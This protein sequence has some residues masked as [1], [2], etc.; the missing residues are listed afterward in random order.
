MALSKGSLYLTN[1]NSMPVKTARGSELLGDSL[2]LRTISA[3]SL[4][5]LSSLDVAGI[6]AGSSAFVAESNR[7]GS[8]FW[9]TSD[10]SEMVQADPTGSMFVPPLSDTSGESGVW[11]RKSNGRY[12]ALPSYFGARLDGVTDDTTALQ[13]YADFLA[14][15][16]DSSPA[17]SLDD[18]I[19]Q[20]AF[21]I[22][23]CDGSVISDKLIIPKNVSVI[24]DGPLLVAADASEAK[25]WVEI[26]HGDSVSSRGCEYTI[27]VRRLT[28]SDWASEE[29]V[30]CSIDTS[31]S[32]KTWLKRID[33]FCIGAKVVTAYSDITLG[34]FRDCKKGM[35]VNHTQGQFTNQCTF[36]GGEFAV[37]NGSNNGKSR[38]GVEIFDD[39]L[40]NGLNSIR[41]SGPSFELNYA[42]A[43]DG[44]PSA[45]SIP[46]IL[47][48]VRMSQFDSIRQ[49]GT[50]P[51]TARLLNDS[52][53]NIF[54]NIYSDEFEHPENLSIDDQSTYKM[55][56]V[57][58]HAT[59]GYSFYNKHLAFD[60]GRLSDRLSYW[61]SS[62]FMLKDMETPWQV[63]EGG[64][65]NSVY[66]DLPVVIE[67]NS[68]NLNG[69][70]TLGSTS[71]SIVGTRFKTTQ[72]KDF[73]V[74]VEFPSS[75]DTVSMF[76]IAFDENGNQVYDEG[77]VLIDANTP[78]EPANPNIY[79]GVF[80]YSSR[81]GA[82]RRYTRF[83]VRDDIKDIFI[84]LSNGTLIG[85]RVYSLWSPSSV[86][87]EGMLR[88]FGRKL[89]QR[90]P[91]LGDYSTGEIIWYE[92]A[93]PGEPAG[94]YVTQGGQYRSFTTAVTA[95]TVSGSSFV[96]LSS[97]SELSRGFY[98]DISGEGTFRIL[99]IQGSVARLSG[100]MTVTASGVGVTHSTPVVKEFSPLGA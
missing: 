99:S 16:A 93:S 37:I 97:T 8:F 38:Y 47:S 29:D 6:T 32:H 27:D 74:D 77:A 14:E 56:N 34:E 19:N 70:I 96:T 71:N 7:G 35:Q 62:Q 87:S 44:N 84:G 60:S 66:F 22:P 23:S 25:T 58:L 79:G 85:Y 67:G 21:V 39:N 42:A 90:T 50:G 59:R 68:S 20:P 53:S 18:N 3:G 57:L 89:T 82:G 12:L 9:V 1:P 73:A 69:S 26:S 49:E 63:G 76:V 92:S 31:I 95:D 11:A 83:S 13:A 81:L 30:G 75:A 72:A 46:F 78:T 48:D 10:S 36:F 28:L 5:E 61:N 88:G 54:T 43:Q 94:Y 33:G 2:D 86:F 80:I 15:V 98:I 100:S 4:E 55:S 24:M 17:V 52:R 45:E 91:L 51:V 41:F 40:G 64:A 65:E